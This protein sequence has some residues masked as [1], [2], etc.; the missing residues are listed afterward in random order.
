MQ[1][2]SPGWSTTLSST[3]GTTNELTLVDQVVGTAARVNRQRDPRQGGYLTVPAQDCLAYKLN[4]FFLV[5]S[6]S[7]WV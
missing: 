5:V 1:V 7:N 2:G 3:A 6:A 4:G